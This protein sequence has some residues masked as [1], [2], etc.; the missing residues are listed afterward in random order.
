[1]HVQLTINKDTI[2][3]NADG[4]DEFEEMSPD[5]PEFSPAT[6][7]VFEDELTVKMLH[8]LISNNYLNAL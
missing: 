4:H 1:M 7:N 8:A 3:L 2:D 5:S 6:N